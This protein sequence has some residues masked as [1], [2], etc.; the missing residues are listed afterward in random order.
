MQLAAKKLATLLVDN[1]VG[2]LCRKHY[3]L[4]CLLLIDTNTRVK[5][6]SGASGLLCASRSMA[7]LKSKILVRLDLVGAP[8]QKHADS[9]LQVCN[10]T[11]LTRY[12]T[13]RQTQKKTAKAAFSHYSPNHLNLSGDD[14]ARHVRDRAT[15]LR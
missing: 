1:F 12:A 11:N 10:K 4:C 5:R 14:H 7:T 15:I 8:S 6:G 3:I 13:N 9:E 2:Y